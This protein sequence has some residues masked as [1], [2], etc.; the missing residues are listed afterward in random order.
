MI[1]H[2]DIHII[3]T[4]SRLSSF[5]KGKC[6]HTHASKHTHSVTTADLGSGPLFKLY[7]TNKSRCQ[8]DARLSLFAVVMLAKV[9]GRKQ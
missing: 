6:I 2:R 8:T 3:D 5:M 1:C 4:Q 9:D 7:W